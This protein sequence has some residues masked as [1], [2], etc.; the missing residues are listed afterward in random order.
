MRYSSIVFLLV[1]LPSLSFAAEPRTRPLDPTAV[2]IFARALD[3]SPSVRSLV[4]QLEASDVIVHIDTS[5]ALPPG[6]GGMTRFVTKSGGQRY[7]RVTVSLQMP[8]HAR[9]AMLA[10]ELKHACEVALSTV[11]DAA[12]MKRLF[13]SE[14]FRPLLGRE[15]F[16]TA[17]A[18]RM[19]QAVRMELK[20]RALP[21]RSTSR[22]A[23]LPD[24]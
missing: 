3:R 24:K 14:G 7:L 19:E 22:Q 10:H 1:L 15:L 12:G 4:S 20:E 9:I 2:E 23:A 17:A 11:Q 21:S 6:V 5:P 18:I 8:W 13:E 16:E